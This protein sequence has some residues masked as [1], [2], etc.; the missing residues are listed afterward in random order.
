MAR[1]AVARARE[2]LLAGVPAV[3]LIDVGE[4]QTAAGRWP[5]ASTPDDEAA[6]THAAVTKGVFRLV[7]RLMVAL[8][9]G[10]FA[11]ILEEVI[12][13]VCASSEK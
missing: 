3:R 9:G 11:L 6:R 10:R 7:F 12:F 8:R 4:D 13:Q 1:L 2:I 5:N